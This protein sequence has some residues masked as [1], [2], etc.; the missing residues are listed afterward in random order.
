KRAMKRYFN[1]FS[2]IKAYLD[3]QKFQ[4]LQSKSARTASGRLVKYEFDLRDDAQTAAAQRY[5]AN[6]SIQ[7]TAADILKTA[8][9][10]FYDRT[11]DKRDKIK[12]VNIVHDEMVVESDRDC[13]EEANYIL[14][15]SLL[16]AGDKYLST[17]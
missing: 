5:A 8:M 15:N 12:L 14:K 3:Y 13:A 2:K 10:L 9:R 11:K 16:D 17:V 6:C 7:G 4:V 1:T